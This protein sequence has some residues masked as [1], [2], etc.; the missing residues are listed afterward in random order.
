[1]Q[2][3]GQ[4][5]SHDPKRRAFSRTQ[6]D[7]SASCTRAEESLYLNTTTGLHV[8]WRSLF[9]GAYESLG[10]WRDGERIVTDDLVWVHFFLV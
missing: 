4:G 9:E 7:S 2:H 8:L 5:H 1:M 6:H 3:A 10:S